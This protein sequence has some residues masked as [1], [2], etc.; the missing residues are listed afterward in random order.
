MLTSQHSCKSRGTD[1]T[2]HIA[3]TLSHAVCHIG[4]FE[5][6]TGT[7]E[8]EREREEKAVERVGTTVIGRGESGK[9]STLKVARKCPPVL[10]VKAGR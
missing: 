4:H 9:F 7:R 8:T 3:V 10:L 2:R 1:N 6:G 5:R